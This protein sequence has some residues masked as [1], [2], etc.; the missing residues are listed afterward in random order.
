MAHVH[1]LN[2]PLC[3]ISGYSDFLKDDFKTI[4]NGSSNDIENVF[5][6]ISESLEIIFSALETISLGQKEIRESIREPLFVKQEIKFLETL[7]FLG[8][9]SFINKIP[10][11]TKV[12]L[13]QKQ[14]QNF[15]MILSKGISK[16]FGVPFSV[17]LD[18]DSSGK[19]RCSLKVTKGKDF[20]KFGEIAF[21]EALLGKEHYL[22]SFFILNSHDIEM[23]LILEE[24]PELTLLIPPKL[25]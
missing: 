6:N 9:G 4:K 25:T 3:V 13:D 19:I 11:E 12:L 2:S 16:V 15:L 22:S 8:V 24:E 7:S 20:S 10:D 17:F 18:W 14:W 1:D 5:G 23:F 21:W